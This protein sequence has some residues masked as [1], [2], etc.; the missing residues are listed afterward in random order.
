MLD[1]TPY[2]PVSRHP[3]ISRDMSVAVHAEADAETL[4]GAVRDALGPYADAVEEI[5]LISETPVGDLPPSA[6]DRLGALPGQKNVLLR[7]V[8][9]DPSRTLADGEANAIRDRIYAAVHR[10]TAHQWAGSRPPE[11]TPDGT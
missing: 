7:V 2:R 5:R 1:L 6:V 9:R 8:L 3:A 11:T 4:G 10:G